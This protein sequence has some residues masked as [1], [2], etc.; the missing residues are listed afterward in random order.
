MNALN[1]A[2]TKRPELQKDPE[3][4]DAANFVKAKRAAA[5]P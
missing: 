4:W 5:K 3:F 2:A 1:V